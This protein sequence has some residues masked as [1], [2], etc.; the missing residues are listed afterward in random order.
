MKI[1]KR[2]SPDCC[3]QII[4][5]LHLPQALAKVSERF[6]VDGFQP[7]AWQ[8]NFLKGHEWRELVGD[9]TSNLVVAQANHLN[10]GMKKCQ[11]QNLGNG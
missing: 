8:I 11:Y 4:V 1:F 3:Q 2:L 9:E 5:K 10:S 6:C 7:G